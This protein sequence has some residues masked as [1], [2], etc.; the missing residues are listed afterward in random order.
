MGGEEAELSIKAYLGA[1]SLQTSC[2]GSGLCFGKRWYLVEVDLLLTKTKLLLREGLLKVASALYRLVC[3]HKGREEKQGCCCLSFILKAKLAGFLPISSPS[4]QK[5]PG[6]KHQSCLR[7]QLTLC[8]T[9]GPVLRGKKSWPK[10]ELVEIFLFRS[11]G[12]ITAKLVFPCFP[13]DKKSRR[14]GLEGPDNWLYALWVEQVYIYDIYI[15]YIL[16]ICLFFIFF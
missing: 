6:A 12:V 11:Y 16:Y 7:Q 8:V 3:V 14:L 5:T 13:G 10:E 15:L 9:E 4:L 1:F 2:L